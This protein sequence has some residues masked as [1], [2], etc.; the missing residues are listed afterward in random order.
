MRN[1]IPILVKITPKAIKNF[2]RGADVLKTL[3][4]VISPEKYIY[5]IKIFIFCCAGY[6]SSK[7]TLL[8]S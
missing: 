6:L 8:F 2:A 1:S 5:P 3:I 7:K 4:R